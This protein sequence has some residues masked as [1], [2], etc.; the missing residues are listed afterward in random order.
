MVAAPFVALL[1]PAGDGRGLEVS[2]GVGIEDGAE[3]SVFV[4]A[5]GESEAFIGQCH[6]FDAGLDAADAAALALLG[7]S[8]RAVIYQP[9]LR[10][11]TPIGVLAI[12]C[13]SRLT[14]CPAPRSTRS[15][16]SAP[17]LP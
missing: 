6:R 8:A 1:E 3:R 16:C 11:E 10:S 9:V 15:N 17:P 7:G 12:A 13:R 14:R 4:D 5:G 2:A